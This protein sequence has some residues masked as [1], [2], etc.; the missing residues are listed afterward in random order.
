M[1]GV[2]VAA[3]ILGALLSQS[4]DV[5]DVVSSLFTSVVAVTGD[6][7]QTKVAQD[8]FR[9]DVRYERSLQ[10]RED[11]RDMS[12]LLVESI[13]AHLF[14]GSIVLGICFSML[15]GGDPPDGANWALA[16]LWLIFTIWST[17]F[18]L[19]ALSLALFYQARI[20][21]ASQTRLLQ[22]HRV[23]TPDE[24]VIGR[25]GGYTV[26][27]PFA[28]AHNKILETISSLVWPSVGKE[29]MTKAGIE[30]GNVNVRPSSH[31]G[32]T[33]WSSDCV[34]KGLHAWIAETDDDTEQRCTQ[35][36]ILDVPFFLVGGTLIRLPWRI[37]PEASPLR[38]RVFGEATLYVAAQCPPRKIGKEEQS[39]LT[40]VQKVLNLD[41]ILPSWSQHE[42]PWMTSG[43][44]TRFRAPPRSGE[45]EHGEFMKVEGFT[46]FVDTDNIEVP[47]YKIVLE[48]GGDV[49]TDVVLEWKF[50][51]GCEAP[52]VILRRGQVACKEEDWAIV[53]FIQEMKTDRPFFVYSG[54]FMTL[55]IVCV[56]IAAWLMVFLRNVSRQHAWIEA[57]LTTIG[58][59]PGLA[60]MLRYSVNKHHMGIDLNGAEQDDE[61]RR[62]NISDTT[63]SVGAQ[64]SRLRSWFGSARDVPCMS[65][66]DSAATGHLQRQNSQTAVA[67]EDVSSKG[68]APGAGVGL[69]GCY[70]AARVAGQFQHCETKL[71][72]VSCCTFVEP[73]RASTEQ[74]WTRREETVETQQ[75]SC[76]V[77]TSGDDDDSVST[78]HRSQV[79]GELPLSEE[80][81]GRFAS[82]RSLVSQHNPLREDVS[83]LVSAR[84]RKVLSL[85]FK[86]LQSFLL[87]TVTLFVFSVLAVPI[88]RLNWLDSPFWD[89][90][91]ATQTTEV[92]VLGWDMLSVVWPPFFKPTAAAVAGDL[93]YAAAGT[94][95]RS[96][97]YEGG[98]WRAHDTMHIL[99]LHAVG[100]GFTGG[101]LVAMGDAGVCLVHS[102]SEVISSR[103]GTLAALSLATS[104]SAGAVLSLPADILPLT[105]GVSLHLSSAGQVHG[106]V[107]VIVSNSG[108][109][110]L[111]VAANNLTS[112][113]AGDSFKQLVHLD[114]VGT[115]L[116]NVT[117]LFLCASGVCADEGVLWAATSDVVAA[118][119]LTSGLVLR[120][121][122]LPPISW[123]EDGEIAVL[124]GN[125][126][127]LIAVASG[128]NHEP[129][130]Y[131]AVF[132]V[133]S[134]A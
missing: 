39:T 103:S 68:A 44:D 50:K 21:L 33:A 78:L 1:F 85:Y 35:D 60:C 41:G 16:T 54:R 124:T 18:T 25:M 65:D 76:N 122:R 74:E 52:I 46:I 83:K 105:S 11:I 113:A 3:V 22:K 107:A 19:T 15:I 27:A 59:F 34:K 92:S 133:L 29:T 14:M 75:S 23:V 8:I 58:L 62:F 57:T 40:A 84:S 72:G 49:G 77:D 118:I 114:P 97:S 2:D 31:S 106:D 53:E 110:D 6:A 82:G 131:S 37:E 108:G 89:T 102:F 128:A 7:H 88:Y 61:K 129:L 73:N 91:A 45:K 43:W 64:A 30:E 5:L 100:L 96:F 13:S 130:T 48:D 123:I 120:T 51:K 90:D 126:T 93:W 116:G 104:A 101:D 70:G 9:Q 95:L 111:C 79:S 32:V 132:P 26:A 125:A 109:L 81:Q 20:V 80:V 66:G 117:S 121:F 112:A 115:V 127:H 99:P 55:G 134:D 24:G 38:F 94:V 4:K 17:T 56:S 28:H 119:G 69:L 36:R 67:V 87:F 12:Q 86:Q 71:G 63:S 10:M 42:L 98:S 47:L